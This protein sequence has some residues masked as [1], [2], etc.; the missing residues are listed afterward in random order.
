[1]SIYATMLDALQ[2]PGTFW[3]ALG[4]LAQAV[5][6][7]VVLVSAVVVVF[8]L[9][10]MRQESIRD[11]IIGLNSALEVFKSDLL[12]KVLEEIPKDAEVRGVNWDEI[13]DQLDLI[14][15][16]IE[17]GYTDEKLFLKLKGA[18]LRSL[19]KYIQRFSLSNDLQKHRGAQQLLNKAHEHMR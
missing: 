2:I 5:E 11:R 18:E 1:M 4:A 19:G 17:Q 6:A 10:R 3:V 7:L 15:L 9:R 14:A 13:F 16:L 8:Q 12:R